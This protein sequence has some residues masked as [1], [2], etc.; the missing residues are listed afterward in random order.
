MAK[1]N[2]PKLTIN[3]QIVDMKKKNITFNI[4]NEQEAKN[5][6]SH[7]NYYYKIKSYLRVFD[8]YG[9]GEKKGLYYNVDFAYIKELSTLDMHFR[10]KIIGISLD[11]EH[12]LKVKMLNDIA[13]NHEED[14][15]TIAQQFIKA[16]PDVFDRIKEKALN[17]ACEKIVEKNSGNFSAWHLA[18]IL[19]FGDFIKFYKTYYST[20][21]YMYNKNETMENNL[22]EVKFL[23]N[24]AA[25]NNCLLNTLRDNKYEGFSL[26]NPVYDAIDKL[27][28]VSTNTLNKKMGN[29]VIHDFIVMLFVFHTLTKDKN[30]ANIRKHT[31][32]DLKSFLEKRVIQ[33]SDYFNNPLFNSYYIFVKKVVDKFAS[34]AL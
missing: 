4:V 32:N 34:Y 6:L 27:K 9:T 23:R 1:L 12:L 15:Y 25:H 24:A 31:F 26:N 29:R 21:S 3:E 28:L 18:E 22:M 30:Y 19:S 16:H 7:N 8:K 10:R 11:I 33:N 5:F 14:G 17:S 13:R 20:Y 2:K